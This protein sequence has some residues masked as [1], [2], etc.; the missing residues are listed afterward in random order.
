MKLK[1]KN[2]GLTCVFF[3]FLNLLSKTTP[4]YKKSFMSLN[5]YYSKD[6]HV[7]YVL[8]FLTRNPLIYF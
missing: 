3:Q 4:A 7:I 5:T 2:H 6:I 1:K 8:Y